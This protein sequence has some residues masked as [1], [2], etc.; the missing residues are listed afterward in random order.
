MKT[1]VY[2]DDGTHDHRGQGRCT[3]CGTPRGNERH[4]LPDK[5]DEMA[6]HRRRAGEMRDE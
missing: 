4:R 3:V 6:E 2:A 1:H 5:T